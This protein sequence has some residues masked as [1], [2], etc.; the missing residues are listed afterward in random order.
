MKRSVAAFIIVVA[1]GCG[2][3]GGG[4]GFAAGNSPGA[5]SSAPTPPAQTA[6]IPSATRTVGTGTPGSVTQAALQA[7]LA[8]GG[9]VVFNTGGAPISLT[10]TSPL[11]VTTSVIFDGGGNFT[12][13]GGNAVQI[14]NVSSGVTFQLQNMTLENG[15]TSGRGGAVYVSGSTFLATNVVF[16]N[17]AAAQSGPNV[18]GGAVYQFECPECIYSNCT[19]SGNTGSNGGA[20]GSLGSDLLIHGCTFTSNRATGT[21]GSTGGSGGA[22]YMD[23]VNH[24]GLNHV[25][26]CGHTTF[27]GNS[28]DIQG[29]AVF[30]YLYPGTSSSASI[31]TTTFDSNVLGGTGGFGGGV[32]VQ[33]ETFTLLTSTFT[34][35]TCTDQG[36][37]VFIEASSTPATIT[38][39][40]FSGNKVTSA[41]NG[42]GAGVALATGGANI[43][44]VTFAQNSAADFAGGIFAPSVSAVTLRNC[45]F[46]N[47]TGAQATNGFSVNRTLGDG[48]GNMQWP[49]AR[50]NGEAD[51]P[52][53][54]GVVFA[55]AKLGA[56]AQNG[57]PTETMALPSG[58]PA[59]KAGVAGGPADDQRGNTRASPPC[60]GAYEAP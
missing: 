4:G 6:S 1:T 5:A 52:A 21:G 59:I 24:A 28:G 47:N 15:S 27:K 37:G 57:G 33:N 20:I 29:G 7:A 48:G 41:A 39:C 22:I 16:Q 30:C 54:Q 38:N 14:F 60:T 11:M 53:A 17:N 3:G 8:Q 40:T 55:D 9:T 46:W 32:Y 13:S 36:G 10:L 18:G 2:G 56:L 25:F 31:D 26:Q 42:L 44:A 34:N 43:T 23:G 19:F 51:T 50:P 35:N 49:A 58:S 45:L 12:L